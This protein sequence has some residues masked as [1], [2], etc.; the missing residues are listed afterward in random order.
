MMKDTGIGT[1]DA[2]LLPRDAMRANVAIEWTESTWKLLTAARRS[3][4]GAS[5]IN[6]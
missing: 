5:P 2:R 1:I 6:E 4:L 3:A